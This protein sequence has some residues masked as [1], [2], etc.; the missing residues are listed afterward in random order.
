MRDGLRFH[1][2]APV[3]T[4]DVVASLRRWMAID[5]MAKKVAAVTVALTPLDDRTF[6]WTV[7][8][9]VPSLVETLAAAPSHFA[10]IARA[11]DISE[12]GKPMLS[13]IGSGPFRFNADLRVSGARVVYDRNPD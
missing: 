6:D 9:P 5:A 10:I 3:T 8:Q 2:G 7:S 1:D 12:P 13:T 11:K 4:A